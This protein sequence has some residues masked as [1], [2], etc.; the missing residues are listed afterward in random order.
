MGLAGKYV[1]LIDQII[2]DLKTITPELTDD[3]EVKGGPRVIKWADPKGRSPRKGRYEAEVKAGPMSILGGRT[4]QSTDNQFEIA[5]DLIFYPNV[6][7]EEAFDNVMGVAERIYDKF[8]ITTINGNCRNATVEL[9]PGDGQF[10]GR[11]LLAIP[12]RI[13]ITCDRV[14]SQT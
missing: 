9:F 4:T 3:T 6:G 13:V 1:A 11:S 7:M 12:V 10:S 14:I 5:I 8:H 2:I